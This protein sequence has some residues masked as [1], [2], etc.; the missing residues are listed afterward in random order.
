MSSDIVTPPY[1]IE[2]RLGLYFF[3]NLLI[4]NDV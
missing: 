3:S 1:R 4:G 2:R